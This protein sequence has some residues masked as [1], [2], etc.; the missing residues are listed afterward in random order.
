LVIIISSTELRRNDYGTPRAGE[1][2]TLCRV[3][4]GYDYQITAAQKDRETV[5]GPDIPDID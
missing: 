5:I 4:P 3:Q 1:A 2:C